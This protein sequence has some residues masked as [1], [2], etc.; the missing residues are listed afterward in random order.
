M[1]KFLVNIIEITMIL[2]VIG[3]TLKFLCKKD[4]K[5]KKSILGK[6]GVLASN[7]IHHKLDM[8]IKTQKERLVVKSESQQD[9]QGKVIKLEKHLRKSIQ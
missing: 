2:M 1:I 8:M 5:Y 3:K 7:K 9:S 6:I 4:K